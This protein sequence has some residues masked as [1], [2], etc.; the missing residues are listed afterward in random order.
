MD[1]NWTKTKKI[2][3]ECHCFSANGHA[4]PMLR[5][6]DNLQ[7]MNPNFDMTFVSSKWLVEKQQPE[8]PQIKMLGVN[9]YESQKEMSEIEKKYGLEA[10]KH[11]TLKQNKKYFDE[12]QGKEYPDL[13]ICDIFAI[14]AMRFAI[15]HN[16]KYIVLVNTM[17]YECLMKIFSFPTLERSFGFGG[18]TASYPIFFNNAMKIG[19]QQLAPTFKN[20]SKILFHSAIGL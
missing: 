15:R 16:I 3:V 9:D 19:F 20:N 4:L 10:C 2:K 13:Y 5:I 8:F 7:K 11:V 14:E 12:F 6:M 1:F 17:P 18:L